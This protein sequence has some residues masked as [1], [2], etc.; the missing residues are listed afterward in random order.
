V[1]DWP[2]LFAAAAAYLGAAAR[3]VAV[4][5]IDVLVAILA[6]IGAG[7]VLKKTSNSDYAVGW[8]T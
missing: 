6:T 7:Q 8:V 1:R 5:G 4:D 3:F 2:I